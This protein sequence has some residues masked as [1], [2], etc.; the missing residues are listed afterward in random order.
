MSKSRAEL[1]ASITALRA[2]Y[3]QLYPGASALDSDRLA[4]VDLARLEIAETNLREA[5]TNAPPAARRAARERAA[6]MAG[7]RRPTAPA[8]PVAKKTPEPK[9]APA[10]RPAAPTARQAHA[11]RSAPAAAPDTTVAPDAARTITDAIVAGAEQ[12]Q[13]ERSQL[14]KWMRTFAEEK[15]YDPDQVFTHETDANTHMVSLGSILAAFEQAP[16]TEQRAIKKNI[17]TLDFK[18]PA[19][20]LKYLGHLGGALARNYEAGGTSATPAQAPAPHVPPRA[21]ASPA[22]TAF[23]Q[24]QAERE[25]RANILREKGRADGVVSG[26]SSPRTPENVTGTDAVHYA[27]GWQQGHL[28]KVLGPGA[29]RPDGTCPMCKRVWSD[30]EGAVAGSQFCP[31]C[32]D[33]DGNPEQPRTIGDTTWEDLQDKA[34]SDGLDADAFAALIVQ[35]HKELTPAGGVNSR[36]YW[37]RQG[38]MDFDGTLS[39]PIVPVECTDPADQKAYRDGYLAGVTEARSRSTTAS[40]EYATGEVGDGV[41]QCPVHLGRWGGDVGC[42][43]CTDADGNVLRSE[44]MSDGDYEDALC[45]QF[46]DSWYL[47]GQRAYDGSGPQPT[48]GRIPSLLTA[49]WHS[50]RIRAVRERALGEFCEGWESA[51]DTAAH[52]G[53]SLSDRL[54]EV[55]YTTDDLATPDE[56]E[57]STVPVSPVNLYMMGKTLVR[58]DSPIDD[59]VK[60]FD[61]ESKKKSKWT[62]RANRTG[63]P[64]TPASVKEIAARGR[65]TGRC[66]VCSTALTGAAA[67]RGIGDTCR[68][69]LSG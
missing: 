25:R 54:A 34:A 12:V 5:I 39:T 19:A 37:E 8:T 60:V 40:A 56:P 41:E 27:Q 26:F 53:V 45:D 61:P 66:M 16:L 47:T 69:R 67:E 51:H 42:T 46:E 65:A 30:G 14:A 59:V 68:K 62:D 28:W 35:K 24:E 11:P 13:R 29:I 48:G 10:P 36:R 64:L 2:Q 58:A 9:P 18:D 3:I 4:G 50:E 17:V 49:D 55:G 21:T 33:R 31:Y 52:D 7:A 63:K 23:A 57:S 43:H 15:G 32:Q 44:V 22:D 38:R 6:K 20:P 1:V